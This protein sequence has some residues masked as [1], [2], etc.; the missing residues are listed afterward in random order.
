M[1]PL[2]YHHLYYFYVI[3]KS[4]SIVKA[5][6]TLLLSQPA[7]STQLKEL[8][9]SLGSPLFE[10]RKQRL[11]LTEEGRFVLDYAESIFEMGRELQDTLKDRPRVGRPVL[12]VG[13]LSGT[14]RA[15]GHALLETVLEKFDSAHINVREGPMDELLGGLREQRLDVLLTDVSV[16]S[17][18]REVLSNHLV[19]KV[20]ILLVAAPSVARRHQGRR[21]LDGAPFILPSSP[22]H[23]YQQIL[24]VLA[25]WKVEPK[26][27]AEV[28]D[29]ELA[30]HLAVSGRGIAPLNAYTVSVNAPPKSLAVLKTRRPLGLYESVYLVSRQRKWPNPMV[31]HL[32]NSFHLPTRMS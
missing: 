26:V 11:H 3:A 28:Q 23:I 21:G 8:E 30:R 17:Q 2:N 25:E 6:E 27:I 5:C 29:A 14:P 19:G 4:G 22:S 15:F 24:D 9:R 10:R 12:S 16:R 7:V 18:E 1:I 31:E 32:V 13:I 20:P